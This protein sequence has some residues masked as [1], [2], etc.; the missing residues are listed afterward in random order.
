MLFRSLR[1][2]VGFSHALA[3]DYGNKLDDTG[4]DYLARVQAAAK[5]MN[6]LIEDLVR[7]S[8][9]ARAELRRQPVDLSALAR[10]ITREL[11]ER[12]PQRQVHWEITDGLSAEGDPRLMR[13]ALENLLGNAWKFTGKRPDPK[14]EFSRLQ[15][16][17][18]IV[19]CVRNNGAGFNMAYAANLFG[20]FQR[21]HHQEEFE[22][23]GIGLATV[24]RIVRRHGG[25]VWAEGEVDKGAAFYF[26]L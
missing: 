25:R 10:V 18:Q 8:Q 20:A 19:Y 9:I 5:R 7:L 21:L 26:T 24:Q 11:Q 17:R 13:V 6:E 3:E 14:I 16:D 15:R 23:T 22:G 12:Q 1:G 2:I 4:R